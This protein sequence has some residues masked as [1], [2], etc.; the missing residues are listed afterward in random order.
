MINEHT[1]KSHRVD[2]TQGGLYALSEQIEV[3][4]MQLA[5]LPSRVYLCRIVLTA[6]ASVWALIAAVALWL[7]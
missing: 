2:S 4:R 1:L 7:R 6:T 3:I 5:G